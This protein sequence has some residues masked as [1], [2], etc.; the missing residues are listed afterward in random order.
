MPTIYLSP[1]LQEFNK[2]ITGKNEQYYMNQLADA[3]EPYLRSNGIQFVRNRATQSLYQVIQQSNSGEFDLHVALHSNAAPSGYKGRIRGSEIY[4]YRYSAK[5]QR[6]A[7]IFTTNFK[8]IYPRA[9]L[10]KSVQ[11]SELAELA[12]VKATSVLIEVAYHDNWQD[13]KWIINNMDSLAQNIT[14]SITLYFGLPFVNIHP[15]Q[16]GTVSASQTGINL[17][18]RPELNAPPIATVPNEA[19]IQ[20][21][22]QWNDW[23]VVDYRGIIGYTSTKDIL[24]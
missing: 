23:Y 17:R 13:A 15:V 20:I 16:S 2:Y 9:S 18:L 5:G 10:V 24:V 3:M 6:A 21:L 1:S 7:D 12:Q 4:Y 19:A 8:K 11:S 22:G 14:E